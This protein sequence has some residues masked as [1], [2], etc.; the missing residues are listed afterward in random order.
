MPPSF[1]VSEVPGEIV[2]PANATAGSTFI[3]TVAL[4]RCVRSTPNT[5]SD[6][7]P[8]AVTVYVVRAAALCGV[9]LILP[10]PES[11][12]R[13]CG[14][15]GSTTQLVGLNPAPPE[16]N[17]TAVTAV[18]ALA[19]RVVTLGVIVAASRVTVTLYLTV[20]DPLATTTFIVLP[21]PTAASFIRPVRYPLP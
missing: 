3:L 7:C 15:C 13:P 5:V 19:L 18:P 1:T 11:S 14:S 4:A 21:V 16:L 2:A 20:V 12:K 10:V 8:V 17:V 6:D 9:P